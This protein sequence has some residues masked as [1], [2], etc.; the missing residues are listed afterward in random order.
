M[1]ELA[2]KHKVEGTAQGETKKIL[3]GKEIN[4]TRECKK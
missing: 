2:L 4:S 1:T 3:L